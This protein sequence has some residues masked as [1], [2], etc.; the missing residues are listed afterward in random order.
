M[1]GTRDISNSWIS[2]SHIRAKKIF[3][4]QMHLQQTSRRIL[5]RKVTLSTRS[6]EHAPTARS[7]PF[8]LPA[9]RKTFHLPCIL[10]QRGLSTARA[11][12]RHNHTCLKMIHAPRTTTA[13]TT[14][15]SLGQQQKQIRCRDRSEEDES[16]SRTHVSP[17]LSLLLFGARNA[18]PLGHRAPS[19]ARNNEPGVAVDVSVT[20]SVAGVPEPEQKLTTAEEQRQKRREK[21]WGNFSSPKKSTYPST[22]LRSP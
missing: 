14:N 12:L 4:H 18:P 10:S 3:Q 19:N 16:Q 11:L 21:G 5:K 17:Q 8:N 2:Q 22:C 13:R 15:Q 9:D 7:P 1:T 20:V 6:R